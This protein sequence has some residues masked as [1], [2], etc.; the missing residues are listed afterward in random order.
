MEHG[1]GREA[2]GPPE[3]AA[4]PTQVPRS[5]RMTMG[6]LSVLTWVQYLLMMLSYL[7]IRR[8]H[9]IAKRSMERDM[10]YLQAAHRKQQL[11]KRMKWQQR[12]SQQTEAPNDAGAPL[13]T[14][15]SVS[16]DQ[17]DGE[18]EGKQKQDATYE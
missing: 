5:A 4:D 3:S 9:K 1:L 10:R 16:G 17:D 6:A 18:R 11:A 2:A 14:P 7:R 8:A 15:S 12:S 13:A